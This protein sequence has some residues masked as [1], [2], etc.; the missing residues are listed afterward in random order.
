MFDQ[1]NNVISYTHLKNIP[2]LLLFIDFEKALDTI[3]WAFVR[4]ALEH[5]G[6]GPSLINW[7]NLFYSDIQSCII[8]NGWSGGFFGLGRGVRQACPL[9]PY[10]FILCAE[11]LATAIR[12]DNEINGISVGNIECKLS[13]YADDTTMILDGSQA[14]LERSFALLDSFGQLSGLRFNCEKTEVL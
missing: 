5:F 6:F 7:I 14:S 11:V 13:Q 3:E 1:Y 10:Q 9:S 12:G 8:N 4:K 2:G